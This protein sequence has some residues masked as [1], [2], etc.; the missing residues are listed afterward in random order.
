MSSKILSSKVADPYASALLNLASKTNTLDTITSDIN[1]LLELFDSNENLVK[2]L[3]NPLYPKGSK[4]V[5]LEKVIAPLYFDENTVRFLMVLLD[6]NRIDLLE[7][8]IEKY[9][10]MVYD[11][12]DIKIAQVSSATPLSPEQEL[13]LISRLRNRTGATEIKLLTNVDPSL[14][15]GLKVQIGSNVIDLSLKGQ[16]RELATQ[17]DTN[18]F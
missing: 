11:F 2:Y 4:K 1:D 10:Q 12:A 5:V 6:R 16:L 17:L 14:L 8:I 7:P 3:E 13:D 18:L 15:G 9:L